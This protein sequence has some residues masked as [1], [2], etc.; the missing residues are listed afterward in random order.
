VPFADNNAAIALAIQIATSIA[1]N[2][3]LSSK[4]I[5]VRDL[6]LL[7]ALCR[8]TIA[9]I[10]MR[11]FYPVLQVNASGRSR[12][13]VR[14]WRAGLGGIRRNSKEFDRPRFPCEV[15]R[16]GRD[17][18]A[19]RSSS[20]GLARI[21]EGPPNTS[22]RNLRRRAGRRRRG[23]SPIRFES[24]QVEATGISAGIFRRYFQ[25]T[26]GTRFRKLS[27]TPSRLDRIARALL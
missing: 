23:R 3:H 16:G 5:A 8:E 10:A 11:L 9:T 4:V 22:A 2:P 21:N 14:D 13:I 18:I 24:S 12:R 27:D 17:A 6:N 19:P 20:R 1:P 15:R 26:R 25:V 7:D